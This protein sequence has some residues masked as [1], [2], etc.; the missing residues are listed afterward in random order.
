MNTRSLWLFCIGLLCIIDTWAQQPKLLWENK[1]DLSFYFSVKT[2][3][4]SDS[5]YYAIGSSNGTVTIYDAETGDIYDSYKTHEA[6]VFCTLFQP[7]GNLLASGDKDGNL[8]VYDYKTKQLK[9]SINAHSQSIN[10]MAWSRDGTM[11]ITGSR[12]NS[13]K[14]WEPASGY[15]MNEIDDVKGNLIAVRISNDNKTLVLGTRA[16]SNGLRIYDIATK[17][18]LRTLPSANLQSLDLSPDGVYIATANLEKKLTVWNLLHCNIAYKLPGHDKHIEDVVFS[19]S[20]KLLASSGEDDVVNIWNL[21]LRKK[22]A[23]IEG[24]KNMEGIAW[25]ANGR[26]LAVMNMDGSL[27]MWDVLG[28]AVH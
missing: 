1:W 15:L 6:H 3:F 14:I 5:K 19:P 16:A 11:L 10:A 26:Y 22:V 8:R 18:E 28:V 27:K 4:S 9:L 17:K 12:D 13:V 24:R 23:T 20:G 2:N 25:S 7:G 21:E